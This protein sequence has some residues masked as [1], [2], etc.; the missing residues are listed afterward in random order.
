MTKSSV[1]TPGEKSQRLFKEFIKSKKIM[2]VDAQSFS[3]ATL[4]H[5]LVSLGASMSQ[6]TLH[7]KFE[8]AQAAMATSVP[9]ILLSEFDLEKGTCGLDLLVSQRRSNKYSKDS[10]FILITGNTS[11][12]AVA[13]AAEEDVDGYILKPYTVDGLRMALMK[14]AI[15]KAYPSP[16]TIKIDEGKKKIDT[17]EWDEAIQIFQGA[18]DLDPKPSLAYFYQGAVEERKEVLENAEIDYRKGLEYNRIHYKCLVGLFDLF[19]AQNRTKE[20]Y[21]IVRQ[22]SRYFPANP[23]R[24]ATV[25]RLAVI[26]EAYDDIENYYQLFKKLDRRDEK[27]V[28]YVCAALVV[29]GKHYLRKRVVSRAIELF[30]KAKITGM[31]NPRLLKEIIL[32]LLSYDQADKAGL[33]LADYPPEYQGTPEFAALRYAIQEKNIPIGESLSQGR[34]L[35]SRGVSEYVLYAILIK[36]TLQAGFI[37]HADAL[38]AKALQQWPEKAEELRKITAE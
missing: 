22:I 4:A 25:L 13:R 17:Q 8:A 19:T 23:D 34:A 11:Q 32:S 26:N 14:Y 21:D 31:R 15:E 37:D 18:A 10:L 29:C 28:R 20:A 36:R 7:S 38:L 1:E 12:A 2:I 33:F 35:I 30:D 16:Y 6:I 9:D 27:L 3:R 5:T 24:L